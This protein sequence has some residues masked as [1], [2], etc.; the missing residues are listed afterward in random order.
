MRRQ[1]DLAEAEAHYRRNLV[2]WQ[3]QGHLPAVAHSVECLA[4]L[5][6]AGGRHGHAARLLGAATEARELHSSVSTNPVEI[7][8]RSQALEQLAA[9]LGEAERD[10]LMAEGRRLSL[11]DAVLL[12]LGRA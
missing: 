1:G 4:F 12:A 9:A 7:A 8:E 10:R 11:E 6:I 5:A 2:A 3:E